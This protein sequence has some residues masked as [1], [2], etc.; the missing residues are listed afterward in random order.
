MSDSAIIFIVIVSVVFR[1]ATV[2]A[3]NA[4]A[5]DTAHP[6]FMLDILQKLS[7]GWQPNMSIMSEVKQS[8]DG[9]ASRCAGFYRVESRTRLPGQCQALA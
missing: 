1:V 6:G 7:D 9:Q 8:F 3:C 2:H 5:R 4:V